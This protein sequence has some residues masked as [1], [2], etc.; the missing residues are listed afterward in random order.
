VTRPKEGLAPNWRQQLYPKG[1]PVANRWPA[2]TVEERFMA[3]VAIDET[4]GCWVWQGALSHGNAWFSFAGKPHHG[5]RISHELF[6]GP[7]PDRLTID[8]TCHTNDLMC[9]GG[10]GCL[11]RRCVNPAHLEIVTLA[12]NKARGRSLPAVNARK[13]HCFRGHELT[14]ENTRLTKYGRACRE[15]GRINGRLKYARH[16]E[17]ILAQQKAAYHRRKL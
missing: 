11:H 10:A 2:Q 9:V 17:R 14:P 16:R 8:H 4:T 15:C 5:H 13:T 1:A 7:I 12:E 6:V 3:K